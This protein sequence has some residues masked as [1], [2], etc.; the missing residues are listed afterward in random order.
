MNPAPN[1]KVCCKCEHYCK[2]VSV[3]A[4]HYEVRT[5]HTCKKMPYDG[6]TKAYPGRG[7]AMKAW[8]NWNPVYTTL[9]PRVLLE[10]PFIGSI[11]TL[12][13]VYDT[14]PESPDECPYKLELMMANQ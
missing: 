8:W 2:E 13:H 3:P 12:W 4:K 5:I 7:F 1:V 6:Y 10:L 14:K 11:G 9:I